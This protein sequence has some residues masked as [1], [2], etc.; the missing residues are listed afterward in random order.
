MIARKAIEP[1]PTPASDDIGQLRPTRACV[2]ALDA[3]EPGAMEHTRTFLAQH[4][5][6]SKIQVRKDWKVGLE[7]GSWTAIPFDWS[8][9]PDAE[10]PL[11]RLPEDK[12]LVPF[13][14][15]GIACAEG[16]FSAAAR[17]LDTWVFAHGAD[18]TV[19][20]WSN[21]AHENSR[22]KPVDV[23]ISSAQVADIVFKP[24]PK[25]KKRA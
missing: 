12:S 17:A 25:P 13:A 15:V 16:T 11:V 21:H 22:D 1:T 20:V 18:G 7:G 14:L 23:R 24:A 9:I 5:Q 10:R 2:A 19:C 8:A 4:L 6:N 3:L